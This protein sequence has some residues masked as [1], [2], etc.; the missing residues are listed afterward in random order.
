MAESLFPSAP[1][2][3]DTEEINKLFPSTKD[4]STPKDPNSLPQ[5]YA[6]DLAE[7]WSIRTLT[8]YGDMLNIVQSV[9]PSGVLSSSKPV[10]LT[11]DVVDYGYANKLSTEDLKAIYEEKL[12]AQSFINASG[13]NR[14]IVESVSTANKSWKELTQE[15]KQAYY[16]SAIRDRYN[17]NFGEKGFLGSA[18]D[19]VSA[20]LYESTW[21]VGQSAFGYRKATAEGFIDRLDAARSPQEVDKIL[22]DVFEEATSRGLYGN[23]IFNSTYAVETFQADG[24]NAHE[25]TQALLDLATIGP[26]VVVKVFKGGLKGGKI[27]PSI[28]KARDSVDV[29]LS[30][31]GLRAADQALTNSLK[32]GTGGVQ[33]ARQGSVA[34]TRVAIP[35]PLSHVGPSIQPVLFYETQNYILKALRNSHF[36]SGLDDQTLRKLAEEE[37]TRMAKHQNASL[38]NMNI[39]DIDEIG[40]NKSVMFQYGKDTGG[41][42]TTRDSAEKVARQIGGQ[43]ATLPNNN[44]FIVIKQSNLSLKNAAKVTEAED[45]SDV[46]LFGLLS[47]DWIGDYLS[48]EMTSKL[49]NLTLAKQGDQRINYMMSV[50]QPYVKSM[51]AISGRRYKKAR[52]NLNSFINDLQNSGRDRAY[53]VDEFEREWF[54]KYGEQPDIKVVEA[55][56]QAMFMNDTRYLLHADVELKRYVDQGAEMVE[57]ASIGERKATPFAK[58]PSTNRM[59]KSFNLETGE[60]K[61]I[62]EVLKEGGSIY[63]LEEPYE[64][65]GK[66]V[67][68][69]TGNVK[70]TRPMNHFDALAYNPGGMREAKFKKFI[71]QI[72]KGQTISNKEVKVMPRLIYATGSLKSAE[73]ALAEINSILTKIRQA[74]NN[75]DLQGVKAFKSSIAKASIDDIN[76]VI[77]ANNNFNPSIENFDDFIKM[78]EDTGLDF[79]SDIRVGFANETLKAEE[80]TG[81][82]DRIITPSSTLMDVYRHQHNVYGDRFKTVTPYGYNSTIFDPVRAIERDFSRELNRKRQ[83]EYIKSSI[84]G[85][86][87]GAEKNNVL[88]T[89]AGSLKDLPLFSQIRNI[90][91][92]TSTKIGRKYDRERRILLRKIEEKSNLAKNWEYG[93]NSLQELVFEKG[94][95]GFGKG[96]QWS[97]FDKFSTDP[98]VSLRGWA[99][100]MKLGMFAMDQLIVQ[101]SQIPNIIAISKYGAEAFAELPALRIALADGRFQTISHLGKVL[102]K[103][104]SRLSQTEFEDLVEYIRTS[105][106][107]KIGFNISE[108]DAPEG[109]GYGVIDSVRKAGRIPFNEGDRLTRLAAYSAAYREWKVANPTLSIRTKEGLAS[110]DSFIVA[111]ADAL[112]AHMTGVS[113]AVWQKGILSL[114]TQFYGYTARIFEQ[115]AFGRTLT[116]LER[117]KLA[118]AQLVLYGLTGT[119]FGW[120]VDKFMYENDVS[121]DKDTY[122]LVKYG[123]HDY[124]ISQITG[125]DTAFADRF[126]PGAAVVETYRKFVDNSFAETFFGPVGGIGYDVVQTGSQA[127][128]SLVTGNPTVAQHD[129]TKFLMNISGFSKP[130]QAWAIMNTGEFRTKNGKLRATGVSQGSAI[131]FMFGAPLQ[132]NEAQFDIL[133]LKKSEDQFITEMATRIRDLNKLAVTAYSEG[134]DSEARDLLNQ[135]ADLYRATTPYQKSRILSASRDSIY[136]STDTVM[137]EMQKRGNSAMFNRLNQLNFEETE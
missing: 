78:A 89:P 75:L 116:V 106:A 135:V 32:N 13:I 61:S 80:L 5:E 10:D 84:E 130:A 11:T 25:G 129:S 55:Y 136:S 6:E 45:L 62:A 22:D 90:E 63:R 103:G 51:K 91:I 100:D 29:A 102:Q 16:T 110:A 49:D 27:L 115:I 107:K 119:G 64:M 71:V 72:T 98:I 12:A 19:F 113:S 20:L 104:T 109:V 117:A 35:S 41:A 21:G 134:R 137:R 92:D 7:R 14:D 122:T 82:T 15:Q 9:G 133:E 34:A 54:V 118:G 56:S 66:V 111:R 58:I 26:G 28:F 125:V 132:V 48:P 108:L 59:E 68:Y 93:I 128:Y 114:G 30:V 33:L 121:L 76:K 99:F 60:V 77:Q 31:S 131:A 69:V 73:R 105:G 95:F 83:A 3:P 65:A 123:L 87:R 85:L 23:N 94:V 43:V 124:L 1:L 53:T 38:L 24:M 47:M 57:F 50:I 97:I 67:E 2:L 52:E 18:F 46:K 74:T 17:R 37:A 127:I 42:F 79:V 70:N 120:T 101:T 36:G 96:K 44:E 40:N 4:L 86:I 8:P 39:S 126:A 112:T 88:R 81:L